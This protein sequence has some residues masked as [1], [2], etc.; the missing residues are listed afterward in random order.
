MK[1]IIMMVRR[2]AV[3]KYYNISNVLGMVMKHAM[4]F[5]TTLKNA[6]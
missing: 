2:I 6:K 5:T 3:K 4:Q 1:N